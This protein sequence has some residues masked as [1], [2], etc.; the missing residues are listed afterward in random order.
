MSN[1]FDSLMRRADGLMDRACLT[2]FTGYAH[3]ALSSA[4]RAMSTASDAYETV[5]AWRMVT[6]AEDLLARML[7]GAD[8]TRWGLAPGLYRA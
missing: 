3:G 1:V 7:R 6:D 2:G 5:E 8:V 4:Q